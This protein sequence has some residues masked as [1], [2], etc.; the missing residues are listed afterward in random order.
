MG[1]D[2]L[3]PVLDYGESASDRHHDDPSRI[4]ADLLHV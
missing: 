4:P 1:A 2:S 3:P